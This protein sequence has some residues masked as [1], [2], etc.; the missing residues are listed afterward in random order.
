MTIEQ[1]F[2]TNILKIKL[3]TIHWQCKTSA[4]IYNLYFMFIIERNGWFWI[5]TTTQTK[6]SS[7]QIT[8]RSPGFNVNNQTVS[9]TIQ[10]YFGIAINMSHEFGLFLTF[11]LGL[12]HTRHFGTQYC[13]K[14]IKNIEMK[15]HFSINVLFAVWI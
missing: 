1:A 14:K 11:P 5:W 13:D 3:C 4:L 2:V 10:K 9:E 12:I 8:R 7:C 6:T 15:R